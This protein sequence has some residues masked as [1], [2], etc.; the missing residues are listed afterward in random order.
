[1][2]AT[3]AALA[4]VLAQA[5]PGRL[6][7]EAS[8]WSADP[9]RLHHEL[10]CIAALADLLHVDASDGRFASAPQFT[11]TA[12]SRLPAVGRPVHVHLMAARPLEQIAAWVQ[13][14][15]DLITVHAEAEHAEEALLTL[16]DLNVGCG[17]AVRLDSDPSVVQQFADLIDVLIMIGT[18][19]GTKGTSMAPQAPRRLAEVR[20]LLDAHHSATSI[21]S[22]DDGADDGA[23]RW[24][25]IIADGGIR[26]DT[27]PSLTLAGAGGVV[28]GSMLFTSPDPAGTLAWLRSPGGEAP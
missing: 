18:P 10:A 4:T 6:L 3:T 25:P 21:H 5:R 20:A 13:A 26:P 14:G 24:V 22:I 2:T 23:A 17:L 28:A 15:A 8:L 9:R 27:V 7:V 19:L 1:M 12:L 16:R 11:P